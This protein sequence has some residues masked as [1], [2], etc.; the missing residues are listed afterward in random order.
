MALS[1]IPSTIIRLVVV[2]PLENFGFK[3][4]QR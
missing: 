2:I 4:L 3:H 1:L